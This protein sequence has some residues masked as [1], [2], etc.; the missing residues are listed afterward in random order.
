MQSI[1]LAHEHVLLTPNCSAEKPFAQTY[2]AVLHGSIDVSILI[3][4]D[5]PNCDIGQI[6][7]TLQGLPKRPSFFAT[8]GDHNFVVVDSVKNEASYVYQD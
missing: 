8:K 2:D 7:G 5:D 1:K 6:Y 4:N 3:S